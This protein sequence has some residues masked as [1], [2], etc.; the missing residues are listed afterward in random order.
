MQT[1]G[2]GQVPAELC[3]SILFG[4]PLDHLVHHLETGGS[5]EQASNRST[6]QSQYANHDPRNHLK[7]ILVRQL[8]ARVIDGKDCG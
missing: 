3:K 1:Y 5:R 6:G 4:E 2:F 8:S 7:L